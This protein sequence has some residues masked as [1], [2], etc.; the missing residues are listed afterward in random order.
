[1]AEV[2][3]TI[4]R[5]ALARILRLPGGLVDRDL[6]RRAERVAARA[7]RTAPGGMRNAISVVLEGAGRGRRAR[8]VLNHH[9]A[10]F[11]TRGTRPHLI[12][13]VR[14][15]ALR[16]IVGGR[17]VYARLVRHPGNAKNDFLKDALREAR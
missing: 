4:D 13:P 11:V 3:V 7:R 2:D 1:M 6:R 5:S 17:V 12:R 8:V 15:R 10:V 16:F 14:A 9:A